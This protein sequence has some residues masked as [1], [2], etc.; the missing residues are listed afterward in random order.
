MWCL[1]NRFF[2]SILH[3]Y[4]FDKTSTIYLKNYL[5]YQ[6]QKTKASKTLQQF[7][8]IYYM[9]YPWALYWVYYSLLF[10]FNETLTN[11]TCF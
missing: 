2:K 9:Q 5:I 6:K 4:G 1:A 8:K 10:F 11:K 3:A 7:D